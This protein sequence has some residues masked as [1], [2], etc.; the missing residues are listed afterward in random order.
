MSQRLNKY[1]D[2][3]QN[4]HIQAKILG[5]GGQGIVFRTKDP[6]LAI[7]L[8]TD[9]SG[10]PVTDAESLEECSTLWYFGSR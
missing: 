6:D 8:V 5:Q 1:V 3:Y 7:K 10:T 9:K 4:L 2:E